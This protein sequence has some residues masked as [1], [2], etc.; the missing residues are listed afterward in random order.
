MGQI[1]YVQVVKKKKKGMKAQYVLIR[2]ICQVLLQNEEREAFN[3]IY[4]VP[5]LV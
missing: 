5:P 4:S 3:N 2:I 1:D